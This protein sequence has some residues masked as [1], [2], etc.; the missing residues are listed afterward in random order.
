MAFSP[1]INRLKLSN[2]RNIASSG[3]WCVADFLH[4]GEKL[5]NYLIQNLQERIVNPQNILVS[6][7]LQHSR[8]SLI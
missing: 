1:L 4:P 3:Q 6:V 2:F 7:T 5:V 8:I